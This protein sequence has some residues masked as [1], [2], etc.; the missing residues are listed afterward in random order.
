MT[1]LDAKQQV[2]VCVFQLPLSALQLLYSLLL[3]LQHPDVVHRGLQN[4]P[5]IP[6]HVSEERRKTKVYS[7]S[8]RTSCPA[9][10]NSAGFFKALKEFHFKDTL[11]HC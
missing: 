2:A 1:D 3:P 4:G 8:Q 9:D 10:W 5:L 11:R 7:Q 6:A